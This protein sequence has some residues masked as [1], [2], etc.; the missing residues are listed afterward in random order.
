MVADGSHDHE[1]S[2]DIPA[3]GR[4]QKTCCGRR[5][6]AQRKKARRKNKD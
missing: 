5:E 4:D 6:K 3:R 2:G 1:D